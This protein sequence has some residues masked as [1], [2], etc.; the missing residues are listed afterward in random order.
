MAKRW[1]AAAF[2]C[3]VAVGC[4]SDP[5]ERYRLGPA[6]QAVGGCI[7]MMGGLRRWESAGTIRAR[8]VV[9]IYDASGKA[10]VNE[11][12]QVI[13]LRAGTLRASARV[14]NGRWV[15]TVDDDGKCRIRTDGFTLDKDSEARLAAALGMLLHRL[16][17]PL[18]LC[19]HGERP[20]AVEPVRLV[21]SDLVR[22]GVS[23]GGQDVVAYYFDAQTNLLRFVTAGADKP[24]R[25]GTV[26]LY[27]YRMAPNG[28]AFPAKISV[29]RI[30][31]HVLIGDEPVLEVEYHQV[32]F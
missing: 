19:G 14:P 23:G 11:Q 15:A 5:Y 20:T 30:G 18:N 25:D 2:L 28:M 27:T 10:S 9:T 3:T 6:R 4:A 26:T 21:G 22:V 17:G 16:R 12:E 31:R 32:R 29:V 8:A 24:A 7:D 1:F 13:D